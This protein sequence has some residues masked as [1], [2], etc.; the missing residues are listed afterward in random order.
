VGEVRDGQFHGSGEYRFAGG[1]VFTGSF[2]QGRAKAGVL[3]AEGKEMS[4]P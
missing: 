2:E 3:R 4:I 1:E